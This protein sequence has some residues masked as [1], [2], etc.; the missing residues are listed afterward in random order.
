MWTSP[1]FVV[2]RK[3]PW[4]PSTRTTPLPGDSKKPSRPAQESSA[5]L[6]GHRE[7]PPWCSSC[8]VYFCWTKRDRNPRFWGEFRVLMKSYFAKLQIYMKQTGL[9][10]WKTTSCR[11]PN[12]GSPHDFQY[13]ATPASHEFLLLPNPRG[14]LSRKKMRAKQS[15]KTRGLLSYEHI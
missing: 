11:M 13:V 5:A 9:I 1:P 4:K 2:P 12:M 10:T 6:G 8:S 15:G 3:Q 7:V 14:H